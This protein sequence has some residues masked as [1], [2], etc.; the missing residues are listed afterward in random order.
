MCTPLPSAQPVVAIGRGRV[1]YYYYYYYF[2]SV[3][4]KLSWELSVL[5][6]TLSR[7]LG[8]MHVHI[9]RNKCLPRECAS[10]RDVWRWERP[11]TESREKLNISVCL[12]ANYQFSFDFDATRINSIT[13][14]ARTSYQYETYNIFLGI[15]IFLKCMT[16]KVTSSKK[17][18]LETLSFPFSNHRVDKNPKDAAM[19]R[20]MG[21]VKVIQ[22]IGFT[23]HYSKCSV[24][25]WRV[26]RHH[27]YQTF[28]LW[29]SSSC[30]IVFNYSV[31]FAR[32]REIVVHL[33]R[34]LSEPNEF[35]TFGV[36]TYAQTHAHI[37]AHLT[38]CIQRRHVVRRRAN[39]SHKLSYPRSQNFAYN[40]LL[41]SYLTRTRTHTYAHSQTYTHTR[42]YAYT[43]RYYTL[44]FYFLIFYRSYFF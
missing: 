34:G 33:H 35:R 24:E 44:L 5:S 7:P 42:T 28:T 8:P 17:R 4:H 16:T 23:V 18:S 6:R 10:K 3:S 31:V 39:F 43:S 13:M 40:L 36:N 38:R 22:L 19:R 2:L 15:K 9:Y 32:R 12:L 21:R 26:N 1:Y 41:W 37:H 27:R 20:C 25:R 29:P 14:N 11:H 30:R